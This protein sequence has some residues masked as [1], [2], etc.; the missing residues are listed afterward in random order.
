VWAKY[1]ADGED[2]IDGK[3]VEFIFRS[4]NTTTTPATPPTSQTDD[5]IPSGWTN[6]ASG[7]GSTNPY[8]FVSKRTKTDGVWSSFS[9]PKLWA[10]LGPKGD[11]VTG[12]AIV[13]RG[14]YS[15]AKQYVGNN[16]LVEVVKYVDGTVTNYY[17]TRT[18]AGTISIGTIPTNTTHWNIFVGQFENI[19]TGLLFAERAVVENLVVTEIQATT[20]KIANFTIT[21]NKL[22]GIDAATGT[23][24]TIDTTPANPFIE[25]VGTRTTRIDPNGLKTTFAQIFQLNVGQD[26]GTPGDGG[27]FIDC[28]NVFYRHGNDPITGNPWYGGRTGAYSSNGYALIQQN[29][30]GT[31]PRMNVAALN[32]TTLSSATG[33][34]S[35]SDVRFKKDI[36][37]CMYGLNAL[38]QLDAIQ[39]KYDFKKSKNPLNAA[40]IDTGKVHLGFKAQ[41]VQAIIPELVTEDENEELKLNITELI[42]VLRNAII[43]LHEELL[44]LKA[45]K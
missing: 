31:G 16:T 44:K 39:F 5:F 23:R 19:A 22:E 1:S 43:E 7:V 40:M 10:Q 9:T 12:P 17:M 25:I 32:A 38:L 42:P 29:G 41:Q 3:G 14:L 18:D 13:Y 2:G 28:D 33:T 35:V 24:V 34:V 6:N 15:P 30:A 8:E 45:D 11:T 4:S 21:N 37:E 36:E 27:F 26:I 20:G